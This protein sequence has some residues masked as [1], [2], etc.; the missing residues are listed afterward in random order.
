MT[1]TKTFSSH[2][3]PIRV[4]KNIVIYMDL[5]KDIHLK[6]LKKQ[7]TLKMYVVRRDIDQKR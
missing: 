7:L 6:I 5:K 4:N 1:E 2:K 3:R